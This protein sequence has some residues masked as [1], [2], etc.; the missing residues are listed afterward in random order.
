MVKA[1]ATEMCVEHMFKAAKLA[2]LFFCQP[3]GGPAVQG[4]NPS[5]KKRADGYTMEEATIDELVMHWPDKSPTENNVPKSVLN[6]RPFAKPLNPIRFPAVQ[7]GSGGGATR[8]N[9]SVAFIE[10]LKRG[11]AHADFFPRQENHYLLS[12]CQPFCPGMPPKGKRLRLPDEGVQ[13][14][15]HMRPAV[16]EL[17]KAASVA[18]PSGPAASG[19]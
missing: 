4:G 6:T 1:K 19:D 2:A 5:T 13:N 12:R 18:A 10:F 17:K 9:Y 8:S 11:S 7:D 14:H 3:S 16:E 15:Q